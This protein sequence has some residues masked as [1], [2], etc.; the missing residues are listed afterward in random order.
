[1]FKNDKN[2]DKIKLKVPEAKI[3]II[4]LFNLKPLDCIIYKKGFV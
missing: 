1:M 3:I 2:S 4:K